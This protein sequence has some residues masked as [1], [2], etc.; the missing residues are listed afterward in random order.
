MLFE[1]E[2]LPAVAC[3]IAVEILTLVG[4]IAVTVLLRIVVDNKL[5]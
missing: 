5:F 3:P 1:E 4:L 2:L